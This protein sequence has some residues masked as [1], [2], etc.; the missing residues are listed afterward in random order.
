[1]RTRQLIDGDDHRLPLKAARESAARVL[2]NRLN[3]S[4]RVI[5]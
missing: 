4:S 5:R 3:R 1:M 2:R